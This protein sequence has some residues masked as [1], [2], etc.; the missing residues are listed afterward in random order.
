M[1]SNLDHSVRGEDETHITSLIVH[2][3]PELVFQISP[4]IEQMAGAE[5]ARV[6]ASGKIIVILETKTLQEVTEAID[7][8]QRVEGVMHATLIF[9]QI[10]TTTSLDQ[11]PDATRADANEGM[12]REASR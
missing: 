5:V 12:P 4:T 2:C 6:E 10:E 9:H 11:S 7:E 1:R 8:I 3:R